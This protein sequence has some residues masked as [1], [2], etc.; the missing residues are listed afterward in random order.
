MTEST[1]F[2]YIVECADD[3]L[4][5]GVA[6]DTKARVAKHNA[7]EGAK[8]T[9]TR[10]PVELVYVEPASDRSTAQ[11][12][13]HEIKRMSAEAKRRLIADARR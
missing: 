4:Y 1:W 5:A 2:V 9:R 11:R 13:E 3:T 7:G 6:T 12:R 10:R 8:Y